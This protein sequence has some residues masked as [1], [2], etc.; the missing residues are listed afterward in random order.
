[1]ARRKPQYK[2]PGGV[3]GIPRQVL[4]SP[5][6]RAMATSARCLMLELQ[7][8]WKPSEPVVHYS[9]RRAAEALNASLTTASR[10][11]H[12][13]AEHGFIKRVGAEDW[14]NG[15]ARTYELTWLSNNGKEPSNDWM[16]W[17]EKLEKGLHQSNGRGRKR[18]TGVT[19]GEKCGD[20]PT[21]NQ[22]LKTDSHSI[23]VS[24]VE[25]H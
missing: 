19:V 16:Q 6:Y 20:S 21:K 8:V 12:E 14:M 3:L 10:S 2:H 13:L 11:F 9:A 24:P 22:Q 7:D 23:T 5:S 1:V 15:K 4:R 25:H 18:F 17:T